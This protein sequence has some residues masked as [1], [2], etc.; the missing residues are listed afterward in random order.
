MAV[1]GDLSGQSSIPTEISSLAS[2]FKNKVYVLIDGVPTIALVDTGA[3]GSV[4]SLVFT[5]LLE[6]KVMFR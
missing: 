1:E 6:Q 4:M 5:C 2:M 3:I